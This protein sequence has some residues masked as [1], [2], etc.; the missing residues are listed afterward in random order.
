MARIPGKTSA[1][2]PARKVAAPKKEAME[3]EAPVVVAAETPINA[4]PGGASLRGLGRRKEA[5]AQVMVKSGGTGTCM[6]NGRDWKEYFPT[7]ELQIAVDGP[8][9]VLGMQKNIDISVVVK[10]GGIR[11]QALAVRLGIARALLSADE[12]YRKTL[13]ANGFLTRDARVKERKKYGLKSARRAPQF[14]KR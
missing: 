10:G 7:E 14:S 1:K 11:G 2:K 6:V 8:Q 5:V 13:R 9:K 12:T 4:L 3:K